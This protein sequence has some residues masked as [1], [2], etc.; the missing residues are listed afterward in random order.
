MKQVYNYLI[1]EPVSQ[2]VNRVSRADR[3]RSC[4]CCGALVVLS[5]PAGVY[6]KDTR[7]GD[8]CSYSDSSRP[9]E[10]TYIFEIAG[11]LDN[12]QVTRVRDVVEA[13]FAE[14][15]KGGGEGGAFADDIKVPPA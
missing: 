9:E 2:T 4:R 14:I 11:H 13:G 5:F 12:K 6:A 10:R 8:I 3:R 15:R 1:T 7:Q